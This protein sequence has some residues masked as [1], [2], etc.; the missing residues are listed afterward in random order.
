M[1]LSSRGCNLTQKPML[2]K[3]YEFD[4][5]FG[6]VIQLIGEMDDS[7]SVID[8][9]LEDEYLFRL[10]ESDLSKRYQNT[11]KTGRKSTPV[12]VI[13]RMIALKHLRDWSYD[14]TILNLKKDEVFKKWWKDDYLDN[15][16]KGGEKDKHGK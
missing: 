7:I 15:N 3:N 2:R 11:T 12:E 9:V 13:L 4:K 14:Q 10:I 5:E 6:V 16:E 1:F 8:K